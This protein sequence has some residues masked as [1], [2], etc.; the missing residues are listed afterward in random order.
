MGR[1]V[2]EKPEFRNDRSVWQC[3]VGRFSPWHLKGGRRAGRSRQRT[4]SKRD[5]RRSRHRCAARALR[6][7]RARRHRR[8]GRRLRRLRSELDR[9]VALKLLKP[10]QGV[11]DT[12]RARL[13][14]EAKAMARLQ[15]PNVVA[16][17]DV[18]IFEDQV[19]LAM[20]FVDGGTLKSWLAEKPRTWREVLDVFVAAGPGPGG[21][22]RGR[23]RPPRLQAGQR[24]AR[25]GGPAARRRLRPRAPGGRRRRRAGGRDRR[26]HS[27]TERR[28]CAIRAA[29]T[30]SRR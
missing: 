21:R 16:V 12:A 22:A 13:L 10:G 11:T 18:G 6:D 2:G 24:A 17:H 23:A 1:Q 14:R 8:D 27:R 3:E 28:R 25:Q 29:S 7:H 9:K 30:R 26:R 15:H 5:G 4:T 20:E 19:F